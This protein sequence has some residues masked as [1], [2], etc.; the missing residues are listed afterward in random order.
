MRDL[1]GS[2][3]IVMLLLLWV[4]DLRADPS[5][6]A[7]SY[8]LIE[9]ARQFEQAGNV[10]E[11]L[12]VYRELAERFPSERYQYARFLARQGQTA[13]AIEQFK[14][15]YAGNPDCDY[16][17]QEISDLLAKSGRVREAIEY[18]EQYLAVARHISVDYVGELRKLWRQI[19]DEAEVYR[20]YQTLANDAGTL[21]TKAVV[22]HL[23]LADIES[24][25]GNVPAAREQYW[26]ALKGVS[27]PAGQ[28]HR[29][30]WHYVLAEVFLRRQWLD[31]A[32]AAYKSWP[33]YAVLRNLGWG[34]KQEGRGL[35]M[36]DLYFDYLLSKPD[37]PDGTRLHSFP[38]TG[39]ELAQEILGGIVSLGEGPT[40]APRLKAA[41]AE[42][43]ENPEPLRHAGQLFFKMGRY[44]E[45]LAEFDRYLALKPKPLAV[46]YGWIGDLC[47]EAKLT[48]DAIRYYEG[49]LRM[50]WTEEDQRSYPVGQVAERGQGPGGEFRIRVLWSL[51]DLYTQ[52]QRWAEAEVCLKE[53]LDKDAEPLKVQA[54][55]KLA[56]IWKRTGRENLLLEDLRQKI[57]GDPCNMA[58]RTSYAEVFQRSGQSRAAVA[59]YEEALKWAP[60]DLSVR[61]GLAR[62]LAASQETGRALA[63]YRA[64]L[65]AACRKNESEFRRGK[66]GDETAPERVLFETARLCERLQDVDMLLD[67]YEGVLESLKSPQVLWQPDRYTYERI[68]QGVS[69]IY[70]RKG[71]YDRAAKLWLAYRQ[72]LGH[73]ARSTLAGQFGNLGSLRPYVQAL[74]KEVEAD[75]NDA[76]G[77]FILGDL[78]TAEGRPQEAMDIYARLVRDA[79]PDKDLD[80]DL[81]SLFAERGR[82]D[83]ALVAC[84][85]QLHT[86]DKGT[87]EYTYKL[88]ELGALYV[89][90]GR[91][92]EAAERYREAIRYVPSEPEFRYGLSA[93]TAGREGN[94]RPAAESVESLKAKRDRAWTLLNQDNAFEVAA[95]LY[96]QILKKAPTD[97]LSMACL[98]RAYEKSGRRAEALPWY[99]KAYALRRWS[100][101]NTD[102]AQDLTRIYRETGEEDKLLKLLDERNDFIAVRDFYKSQG[103]P[104]KF[105]QYLLERIGRRPDTI[106][107]WYLGA[108]Y[109]DVGNNEAATRVYE[110]LRTQLVDGQGRLKDPIYAQNL[111][112]A[113][114]RLHRPQE[115]LAIAASVSFEQEADLNDGLG[116]LLTRLY[117]RAGQFDKA[118]GVCVLRLKKHPQEYYTLEIA[119]QM[120]DLFKE[121]A[122]GRKLIGDFLE[123]LR[124]Q[125][126]TAPYEQFRG[127]LVSSMNAHCPPASGAGQ[128]LN[129][130]TLLEEGRKVTVPQGCR[131]LAELLE[132]LAAQA[133]TVAV[134]PF[135]TMSDRE[136]DAPQVDRTT[137]SAFEILAALLN[138]TN[139]AME[140]TQEGH[141]LLSENADPN[142]TV[143]YA[144]SGGLICVTDGFNRRADRQ[145]PWLLGR[146]FFEPAVRTQVVSVQWNLQVIEAVDDRGR[147]VPVVPIPASKLRWNS[148]GQVEAYLPRQEPPATRIVKMRVK[149]AVACRAVLPQGDQA[150]ASSP[151]RATPF[152]P[153]VTPSPTGLPASVE[154]VPFELTFRDV[155][156]IEQPPK[157]R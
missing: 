151:A 132:K 5:G 108:H 143:S 106:L 47:R 115:A 87:G 21:P 3:P 95:A 9:T 131:N 54:K 62:A 81:A 78:L 23:V 114:E 103:R 42:H 140:M 120:A 46:D 100:S 68:L 38:N 44:D 64:V 156:I 17:L 25:R 113:F 144:A 6:Q 90:L 129:P 147:T 31:D 149:T 112:E 77:R 107:Q 30:V 128:S 109:L 16:C 153:A 124:G 72:T 92:E 86:L 50:E 41:V 26:A 152:G 71:Q 125:I 130:L 20:H 127:V 105:E 28:W 123:N 59:Q 14:T 22:A 57:A 91:K 141:W 111:G 118:F 37:Q 51:A 96:G 55:A 79:A 89:K 11:A 52:E 18:A 135:L 13:E 7:N 83:L 2:L 69:E 33:D 97:V 32:V 63:Q 60:N 154:I 39:P 8:A 66:G 104:E 85:R 102:V 98:A 93:A 4:S 122:N 49:A 53:I 75:P 74:Q 58:V 110:A 40:L 24:S 36:L 139:V 61:L 136:M 70:S 65:Y 67:L 119:R 145:A 82:S 29:D 121:V 56:E 1:R 43:P 117:V 15:H 12:A 101:T 142:R 148:I 73:Y 146:V 76:W 138:G 45:G 88:A 133:D 94:E 157:D 27:P 19:G 84:E 126:P 150:G 35:E 99:E 48:E 80:R 134:G 137:G 116:Q 34:L 155:P 10:K